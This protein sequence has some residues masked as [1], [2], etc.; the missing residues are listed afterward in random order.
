MNLFTKQKHRLREQSY[1]DQGKGQGVQIGS[2]G[3]SCTHYCI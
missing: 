3:L 1:G 2:L